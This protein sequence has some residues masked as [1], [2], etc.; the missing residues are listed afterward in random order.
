MKAINEM[1]ETELLE[2]MTQIHERIDRDDLIHLYEKSGAVAL[3]TDLI[4][5][6]IR[7]ISTLNENL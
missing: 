5:A 4:I 1:N 7:N 3:I 2:I 6:E